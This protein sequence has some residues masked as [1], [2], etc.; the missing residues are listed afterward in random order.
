M[1]STGKLERTGRREEPNR[2][3]AGLA[4]A[5]VLGVLGVVVGL[6]LGGLFTLWG[7]AHF[8]AYMAAL[9]APAL[10]P[11]PVCAAVTLLI[12]DYGWR[13]GLWAAPAALATL[14]VTGLFQLLMI[15]A[16][17]HMSL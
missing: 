12:R 6:P 8:L 11:I 17:A 7:E 2:Y 3:A 4:I 16:A 1:T 13:R 14:F 9:T 5:Y 15:A 10:A